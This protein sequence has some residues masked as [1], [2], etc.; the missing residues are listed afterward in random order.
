[1]VKIILLLQ[2]Y[3]QEASLHLQQKQ[4]VYS[5]EAVIDTRLTLDWQ[6][7]IGGTC[8]W[9]CEVAFFS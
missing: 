6:K 8:R 7:W 3:A 4:L 9:S 5:C 2:F 1:M